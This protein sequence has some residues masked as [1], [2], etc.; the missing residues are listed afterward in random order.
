ME[1]RRDLT[2]PSQSTIKRLFAHSGN[3][4]A[5]PRCTAALIEGH[6]LV[7]E[8]CHIKGAKPGA[9][10]YDAQQTPTERH[11]Y[12]NLI[13]LCSKHHT[14]IDDDEVAYT[15][16]RLL[17]MKD[18]HEKV[19]TKSDDTFAN[20]ATQFLINHSAVS[21]NQS[22]G[23]TANIQDS[24]V[25]YSFNQISNPY[26]RPPLDITPSVITKIIPLRGLFRGVLGILT[27]ISVIFTILGT[28]IFQIK[29]YLPASF[30]KYV[31][32]WGIAFLI[33]AILLLV[34][35][36]ILQIKGAFGLFSTVW[37]LVGKSIAD[38][39]FRRV[40]PF[41][42]CGGVMEPK[43]ISGIGWRWVCRRNPRLHLV[44]YDYTQ[45]ASAM[46]KGQLASEF[47]T[48][49]EESYGESSRRARQKMRSEFP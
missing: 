26:D 44:E 8:I 38:I 29:D 6:T 35:A 27:F 9:P 19:A 48:V 39:K 1:S 15:V 42:E 25:R 13:L 40:C 37:V 2:G 22:G 49:I 11:G 36:I 18:E 31:W 32:M 21:V 46:K 45:V 5:F 10:R 7:G 16:E 34:V 30:I 14:V 24:D 12:D 4:C 23:I 17:K 33:P 41:S 3:R 28:N 47:K 20:Q 43:F